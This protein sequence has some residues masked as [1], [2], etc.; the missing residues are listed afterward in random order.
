MKRSF[1]NNPTHHTQKINPHMVMNRNRTTTNSRKS[2]PQKGSAAMGDSQPVAGGELHQIAGR[3]HPAIWC[4][5]PPATGC[6]S[7]IAAEP[8]C[9][10]LFRELVVVLFL[11]MTI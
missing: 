11:F 2:K 3:G 9:G 6:E 5:S 10:L 4:S 8:F 1:Q 7:P